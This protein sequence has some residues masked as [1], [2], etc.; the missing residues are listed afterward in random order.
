MAGE[1]VPKRLT[2][3]TWS[4]SLLNFKKMMVML[5]DRWS[6]ARI[7]ISS[8]NMLFVDCDLTVP[9]CREATVDL[10]SEV[11]NVVQASLFVFRTERGLHVIPCASYFNR[12]LALDALEGLRGVYRAKKKRGVT[13][14]EGT[15]WWVQRFGVRYPSELELDAMIDAVSSVKHRLYI[16][17]DAYTEVKGVPHSACIDTMHID[18]SL[19]RHYTTLRAIPKPNKSM[20]I[21]FVGVFD[22][23]LI[24]VDF[25]EV[26]E[27]PARYLKCRVLDMNMLTN[28]WRDYIQRSWVA[29]GAT[30]DIRIMDALISYIKASI[31]GEV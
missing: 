11:Y 26:L 28:M 17:E 22:G 25:D 30:I 21:E 2:R 18:I 9:G 20:D 27:R 12:G 7:G 29:K 31:V 23:K 10:L 24:R 6:E 8:D 3:R 1:A 5:K 16:W 19:Q 15:A 4:A 13:E 14:K